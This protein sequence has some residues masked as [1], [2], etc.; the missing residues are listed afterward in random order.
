M[1]PASAMIAMPPAE[2]ART[3]ESGPRFSK[4][5]KNSFVPAPTQ[6]PVSSE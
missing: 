3:E 2:I 1:T 6:T 4:S 5:R